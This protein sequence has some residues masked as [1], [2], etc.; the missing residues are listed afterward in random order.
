MATKAQIEANRRNARKSTGPRTA[1]GKAAVSQNALRHGLFARTFTPDALNEI[2]RLEES[3]RSE[4]QPATSMEILRVRQLAV[5]AWS[6]IQA[7]RLEVLIFGRNRPVDEPGPTLALGIAFDRDCRGP[8]HLMKLLRV[9]SRA[10]ASFGLAL[11]TIRLG[12]RVRSPPADLL[13]AMAAPIQSEEL[14]R[15]HTGLPK[16]LVALGLDLEVELGQATR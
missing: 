7:G 12:W 2:R 14:R 11:F 3:F 13:G 16:G 4:Y 9:R 10:A 5:S 6:M 15:L 8:D 1:R